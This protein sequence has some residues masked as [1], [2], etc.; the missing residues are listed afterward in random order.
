MQET[1]LTDAEKKQKEAWAKLMTAPCK[2][3]VRTTSI[4][5]IDQSISDGECLDDD[6]ADDIVAWVEGHGKRPA[7]FD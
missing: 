1:P 6:E 5:M 7:R 3:F 2:P 4:T